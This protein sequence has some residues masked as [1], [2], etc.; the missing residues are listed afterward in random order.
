MRNATLFFMFSFFLFLFSQ[1]KITLSKKLHFYIH[2]VCCH[3]FF[4]KN[5][6]KE[7]FRFLIII[8]F[9]NIEDEKWIIRIPPNF[10]IGCF[11]H[12]VYKNTQIDSGRLSFFVSFTKRR[13]LLYKRHS[14]ASLGSRDFFRSVARRVRK[15]PLLSRTAVIPARY[16]RGHKSESLFRMRDACPRGPMRP[17]LFQAHLSSR[18]P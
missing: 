7:N 12:I 17:L 6:K 3:N 5:A 13:L 2:F 16:Q 14:N 9:N 8:C 4:L 10:D 18:E 1:E 11:F 15:T